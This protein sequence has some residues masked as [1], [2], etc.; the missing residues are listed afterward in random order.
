M[1]GIDPRQSPSFYIK[2]VAQELTRLAEA[3]LRPLNL[4]MGSLPVL[5]ALKTGEASTQADLARLLHVEQPSMAQTLARLERDGFIT[6]T[7]L[8]SNRRIQ[9]ID[10]TPAAHE[11]LP[12]SK[13][14]LQKGNNRSLAGFSP[15]D[16]NVLL[17]FL[18]RMY[19]NI[20]DDDRS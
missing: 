5:T 15:E 8:S 7:P 10:L 2:R 14:L 3:E 4:G 6:R 18:R 17:S 16:V 11:I 20:R 19:A 1:D 12:Q 13:H 9:R